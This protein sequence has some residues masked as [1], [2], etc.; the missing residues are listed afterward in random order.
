VF[1]VT[2]SFD[3]A[4][5]FDTAYIPSIL[6]WQNPWTNP[7]KTSSDNG[8]AVTDFSSNNLV[9]PNN[10]IGI[11]DN[12]HNVEI[13]VSF[14]EKPNSGNVGALA[15]RNIDALRFQY[16]IFQ[17]N[18]SQTFSFTYRML[19][20]SQTSFSQKQNPDDLAGMFTTKTPSTFQLECRSYADYIASYQVGFIIYDSAKF[21]P[22]LLRSRQLQ[23]VYANNEFVVLKIAN[24]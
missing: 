13:A 14:Q 11:C 1:I 7:S 2:T 21:N 8:W 22:S 5:T 23:L 19:A 4:F 18:A 3:A 6:N 10:N 17:I 20:F 9:Y 12:S 16:Q 15:N 24:V